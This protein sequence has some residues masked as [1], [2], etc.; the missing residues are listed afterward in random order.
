MD[1]NGFRERLN[2]NLKQKTI[3]NKKLYFNN[4]K[5]EKIDN[6]L[7]KDLFSKLKVEYIKKQNSNFNHQDE[8][9]YINELVEIEND[10]E[11]QNEIFE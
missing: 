10:I 9:D 7:K 6:L 2:L 8:L 5:S 3:N 11:N 4:V 1:E